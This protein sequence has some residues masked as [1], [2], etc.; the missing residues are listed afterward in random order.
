M[1]LKERITIH[2]VSRRFFA[3]FPRWLGSG[4]VATP[5]ITIVLAVLGRY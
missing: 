5:H 1:S 3:S 4:R 2:K